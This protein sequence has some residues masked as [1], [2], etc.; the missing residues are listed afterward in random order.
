[1]HAEEKIGR[2]CYFS[3]RSE[4]TAWGIARLKSTAV[5]DSTEPGAEGE[6]ALLRELRRSPSA[7]L[8]WA[9]NR[10]ARHCAW[11]L[12]GCLRDTEAD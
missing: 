2:C 5:A 12:N 1:M 9:I 10:G 8:R 11:V 6:E 4:R 7:S 3:K